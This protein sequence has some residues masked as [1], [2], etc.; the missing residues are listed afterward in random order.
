[1]G[2]AVYISLLKLALTGNLFRNTSGISGKQN[3]RLALQEKQD[4]VHVK[5]AFSFIFLKSQTFP[6]QN[7]KA[8]STSSYLRCQLPLTFSECSFRC[9]APYK[10]QRAKRS[11]CLNVYI[12]SGTLEWSRLHQVP[13]SSFTGKN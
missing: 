1:M 9:L 8:P 7:R 12:A 4:D 3:E 11:V 10:L 5:Y 2:L 6:M 13:S